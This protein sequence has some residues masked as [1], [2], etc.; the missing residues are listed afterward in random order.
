MTKAGEE[1]KRDGK[2][3][4]HPAHRNH[5]L[6]AQF[7]QPFA[8]GPDLRPRACGPR[9][10]QPQFLHQDV[11]RRRHQYPELVGQELRATGAVD[12]QALVQ[13]LNAIFDFAPLAI[14]LLVNPARALLQVGDQEARV[15]FGLLALGRTTSA[16]KITR[17]AAVQLSAA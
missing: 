8:Q 2:M 15:V 6:S 5:H 7:Q 13:F 10:P 12:L 17:R 3:N 9:R 4:H 11:G 16:L 14:N 1:R